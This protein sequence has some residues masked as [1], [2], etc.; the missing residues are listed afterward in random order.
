M[1]LNH[2][3]AEDRINSADNL[4]N[5]LNLATRSSSVRGRSNAMQETFGIIDQPSDPTNIPSLPPT[6]DSLIDDVENRLALSS[7]Y[8]SSVQV[9]NDAVQMLGR[10]LINIDPTKPEKL[11]RIASDMSRI[12]ATINDAKTSGRRDGSVVI[13]Y[14]P[15][16]MAE[17]HYDVVQVNE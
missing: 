6:I 8:R 14:K 13:V 9:M 16:M 2:E 7:A 11:S 12:V 10:N 17:N 5:R 4:I 3:D 15:V 1:I